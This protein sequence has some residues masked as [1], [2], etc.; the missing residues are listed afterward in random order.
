MFI[1][2]PRPQSGASRAVVR[3][4]ARLSPPC[5]AQCLYPVLAKVQCSAECSVLPSREH[6]LSSWTLLFVIGEAVAF[7]NRPN[8]LRVTVKCDAGDAVSG[9]GGL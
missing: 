1:F 4:R 5:A 3:T 9:S 7:Q 2:S 8:L 6:L